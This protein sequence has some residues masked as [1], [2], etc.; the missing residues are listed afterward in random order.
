MERIQQLVLHCLTFFIIVKNSSCEYNNDLGRIVRNNTN[1]N[2]IINGFKLKPKINLLD[3]NNKESYEIFLNEITTILSY[4]QTNISIIKDNFNF[5]HFT[6]LST[7]YLKFRSEFNNK[8]ILL[9]MLEKRYEQIKS[10]SKEKSSSDVISQLY[11]E[12]NIFSP[13]FDTIFIQECQ[14]LLVS[15]RFNASKIYNS[16]FA[17]ELKKSADLYFAKIKDSIKNIS[18]LSYDKMGTFVRNYQNFIRNEFFD[19]I[20]SKTEDSMLS[21]VYE[22][23][24]DVLNSLIDNAEERINALFSAI[25]YNIEKKKKIIQNDA[26]DSAKTKTNYVLKETENLR[27]IKISVEVNKDLTS[28]IEQDF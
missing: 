19:I 13:I 21:F 12:I 25:R 7:G 3:I 8:K 22:D 17:S 2:K 4:S 15:L 6:M 18:Y 23:N 24:I 11:R 14:S 27:E 20:K 5:L 16:F 28:K 1:F 10:N 9:S 26:K